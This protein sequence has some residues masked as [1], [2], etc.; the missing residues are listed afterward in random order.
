MVALLGIIIL[1]SGE[2]AALRRSENL[3][4]LLMYSAFAE[5]G[6]VLLGWS[7]GV[8]AGEVG[9]LLHLENQILMRGLAF[10]AAWAIISQV[11]SQ[12]VKEMQGLGKKSP[13]LAAIFA[14]GVF[15]IMGLSPFKGSISKFLIIYANIAAG[16]YVYACFAIIGSIIEAYY[17]IMTIQEICFEAAEESS[18]TG[19]AFSKLDVS[20][21]LWITGS[22]VLLS[23]LTAVVSLFPEFM[24]HYTE[25]AI[26][27]LLGSRNGG[28]I[29]VIDYPWPNMV[30]LPYLGAFMV[31]V[32][33]IFSERVR[34]VLAIGIAGATV[35][36]VWIDGSLDALSH[37]FTVIVAIAGL[38]CT[39]YSS[40]YVHGKPLSN[41]YMFFLLFMLASL[42]GVTSSS[43]L[44][45]F[46]TFWE[47]MTWSSYLLVV[48]EQTKKA[49]AAGF[50]YFMMCASGAY[51]MQLG[52]LTLYHHTGTFDMAVMKDGLLVFTPELLTALVAAFL[53]G[54]GVKVGVVPLHSWLP[55]A[56]PVAPSPISALLSGLLTKMGIYGLVRIL[57]VMLG[58][59]L[60][61]QA[62]SISFSNVG[63]MISLLGALTLLYGEVMALYQTDVKRM[64]AFSTM[65]QL[66]EIIVT[67]GSGT[68]LGVAASVYHVLNHAI[69]KGLLFLAV[70]SLIYRLKRQDLAGFKGV[71]QV[72]PLTAFCLA[73]G[74]LAIMG[75]PPFSGFNSKFLMLYANVQAGHWYF[76]ALILAG[77]VIGAFYYMKLIRTLFFEK[78]E[79]PVVKEAPVFMLLPVVLLTGAVIFNGVF[80]QAT[81]DMV[82][83]AANF[84][85]GEAG[86]PVTAIPELAVYWPLPVIVLLAG[87]LMVY[88][89]GRVSI[90][91]AGWGAVAVMIAALLTLA[92]S[93]A[94]YDIFSLSFAV[95]IVLV[96]AFN[97]VYSIG[98]MAHSHA[99]NRYYM[100]FV[101]M[102]GGLVGVALSKD[103]FSFFVFWEIMSS[104]TLYFV[105]IH[106]ESTE[107]LQEG[108]KYFV[109]NY[110]GANFIFLGMLV[111]TA[112]VGSFAF[113]A[114]SAALGGLST[115][116]A[117]AGLIL[118]TAGFLMKAA[119]L[120]AR[121]DYQMHP[122]AAPT[123]VSGYISAVLLKSAP[124]WLIKLFFGLSGV[125]I[126]GKFGIVANAS[127]V[128]YAVSWIGGLT[129]LGGAVMAL[130]QSGIKLMLIYSTVS[131]IGYIILGLSLGS[132][133]G[134]AAG[135]LH[136]INHMFFKNLLFLAA[137]AVMLQA[138][139]YN[140]NEVGGLGR[141]MPFTLLF[142]MVGALSLAG[143]PPFN[144]FTS[145][146]LVYEAAME[147]GYVGLAMISL[148]ASVLTVAYFIK[149]MHSAFFGSTS[150]KFAHVTDPP[151]TMLAPMGLLSV[152]CIVFGIM[153]GIPLQVIAAIQSM[154]AIPE[155][156]F[157]LTTVITPLGV[158]QAGAITALLLLTGG[159]GFGI[160]LMS[161]RNV[162]ASEVYTCGVKSLEPEAM[163]VSAEN[164]YS[165]LTKSLQ[166]IFIPSINKKPAN[167]HSEATHKEVK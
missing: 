125:A 145:K 25:T 26:H 105:I 147:Q 40:A 3:I 162:R 22:L 19:K 108:F 123:P 140:L 107:A 137:G 98:Y 166:E 24:L 36:L 118:M 99:Q 11:G 69:M 29:P 139:A 68:Y 47:L 17:F 30:L 63:M 103:F 37:I 152:V 16:H 158:W 2:I 14:F 50:K 92:T 62:G 1:L 111:L 127:T 89:L 80:P 8:Y 95:L 160:Y 144:G 115:L 134:T 41:R 72:M 154:L 56:H 48:H 84:V 132:T 165:T 96:G 164:L 73:I 167:L 83:S 142:F 91:G 120:P 149:F 23:A 64:L 110:I 66:G 12:N 34:S 74:V 58:T 53:V 161:S 138:H 135:L 133:L 86:L 136:F 59:A 45:N 39:V 112:H 52:I 43:H 20:G 57:F 75:L 42:I 126:F 104:W 33:G 151:W 97:L 143:I 131:Q 51:L 77:S 156:S 101:L 163:H 153:P 113:A 28:E 27:Q 94:N 79:G 13:F 155:I 15:S 70:G 114:V 157:T 130:L 31:F 82:A 122:A 90:Q 61:T 78:Y 106:E 116:V 124:F 119:V 128:T 146:W 100:F 4:S 159:M 46:Y 5:V 38:L 88:L 10:L 102:I 148:V 71:G 54:A 81:L 129:I 141:K 9:A 18:Q 6:Y 21:S 44:S 150:A 109:F 60:L 76:A 49:L 93:A 32:S 85:A 87:G 65:A 121:I 67:L 35:Y 117:G 7:T 55:A